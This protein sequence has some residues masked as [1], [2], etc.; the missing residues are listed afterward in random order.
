MRRR[1]VVLVSTAILAWTWGCQSVDRPPL[2]AEAP[3]AAASDGREGD[4][5]KVA[6]P[7]SPET[8]ESGPAVGGLD[9]GS[10]AGIQTPGAAV[11]ETCGLDA[12]VCITGGDAGGGPAC[13]PTGPRDCSSDLDNDCDGQP[14]S[15]VDAVCVCALGTSEA[16]DEH[17]GLDGNGPCRAGLR[18]CVLA[19]DGLTTEWGSC[20]GAV[21]PGG[22]DS[23]TVRGDDAD[24]DGTPNTDCPCVDGDTQECGSNTDT[25]PCQI[26]TSTCVNTRFGDCIGA[27]PPAAQDSCSPGDDSNC[28][29][30]ANDRFCQCLNGATQACGVT[31]TGVCELG[32]QTCVNGSF[33]QCVGEVRPASRDCRS[34]QDNDCNGSPDNTTDNVCRCAI[35]ATQACQTHPGLDGIGRCRAGSQT[36]TG[37]N[38]NS[39]SDF[40][41][42][43]GSQGPI[44]RDCRSPQDNDCDGRPDNTIDNVCE[45]IPGAGNGP[46][47]DDP[48]NSRCNN[49][50]QCVP[51]QSSADCSL[52]S[53]GRNSCEDGVCVEPLLGDGEG[54]ANG[55]ECSSGSCQNWFSDLDGDGFGVGAAQRRCGAP[56]PELG[57]AGVPGDCCD[58]GGAGRAVAST[59]F[60]G[61]TMF[62]EAGQTVCN[63]DP[64]D[65]DCSTNGSVSDQFGISVA[66]G[67]NGNCDAQCNGV[68][69]VQPPACGETGILVN[70]TRLAGFCSLNSDSPTAREVVRQCH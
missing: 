48:N 66:A 29:G 6:L 56:T 33:G 18:T 10:M 23:C 1:E 58:V 62:F 52:V 44:A 3:D 2:R 54:C 53:G 9:P 67:S 57:G 7:P 5:T 14:D 17:P 46:C 15:V 70:C 4:E 8:T 45:C 27:V 65:Y 40:N 42:C 60:P 25:G 47:S 50:G 38:N 36:C 59:V 31:S 24:C 39:S 51:C 37:R 64:F 12:G 30:S 63:R 13:T 34:Q 20:E 21:E 55:A 11:A 28:N 35:G 43:T 68:G 32:T 49:Q 61:Q 69:W 16:C 26:G 41:A 19:A 22:P